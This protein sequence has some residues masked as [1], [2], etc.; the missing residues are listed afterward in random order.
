MSAAWTDARIRKAILCPKPRGAV[1]RYDESVRARGEPV[2]WLLSHIVQ[3]ADITH[4]GRQLDYDGVKFTHSG[5][6]LL[7]PMPTHLLDALATLGAEQAD[8]ELDPD[9][10][11]DYDGEPSLGAPETVAQVAVGGRSADVYAPDIED[12]E[13]GEASGDEEPQH[14]GENTGDDE[15]DWAAGLVWT[16]DPSKLPVFATVEAQ[17]GRPA[18]PVI[19]HA[20]LD[21][22]R[23]LPRGI[24]AVDRRTP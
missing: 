2:G 18:A 7:V 21:E 19:H 10:E 13:R 22:W 12:D 16:P 3:H 20:N 14:E 23:P 17:I 11:P 1:R 24:P 6:W 5:A 15:P 8:L 9:I 4:D